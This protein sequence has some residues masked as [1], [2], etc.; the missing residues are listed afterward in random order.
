MKDVNFVF[1]VFISRKCNLEMQMTLR[2]KGR[3]GGKK[4][5]VQGP[6]LQA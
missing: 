5:P 2:E 3:L 6:D 4:T 1:K